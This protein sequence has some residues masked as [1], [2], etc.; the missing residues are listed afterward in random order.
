[1]GMP[2]TCDPCGDTSHSRSLSLLRFSLWLA[3]EDLF[4]ACFVQ[5]LNFIALTSF[6][7]GYLPPRSMSTGVDSVVAR[8][9]RAKKPLG[10][11]PWGCHGAP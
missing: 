7:V 10:T 5:A 1:M 6:E 8:I 2:S 3:T 9:L 4:R 11:F